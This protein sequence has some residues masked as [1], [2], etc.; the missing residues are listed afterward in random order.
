MG[1]RGDISTSEGIPENS[2]AVIIPGFIRVLFSNNSLI[3]GIRTLGVILDNLAHRLSIIKHRRVI[4][5]ALREIDDVIAVAALPPCLGK[6]DCGV[7]HTSVDVLEVI[8]V[9]PVVVTAD[10]AHGIPVV[11]TDLNGE[12][13]R[14]H[15]GS[16]DSCCYV[17]K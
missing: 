5:T 11:G 6:L 10:T 13:N 16:S 1:D 2:L 3:I 12:G 4:H 14:Y 15:H 17:L 7:L 9:V 8:G